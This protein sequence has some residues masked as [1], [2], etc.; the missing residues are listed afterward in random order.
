MLGQIRRHQKWLMIVIAGLTIVSFVYFLDPTT[1]RR[2][3]GGIFSRGGGNYGSINGRSI[4]AEEYARMKRE[5]SLRFLLNYGRWPD[6][7]ETTR[8]MF[9]PDRQTLEWIFLVEKANELN[10]QV[11]DDAITDWIANV[12]RDRTSGSFR[13]EAYQEFVQRQLRPRRLT[14]QDFVRFVRDQVAVQHL[15]VLA[16]LSGGLITPREAEALYREENEQLST[17]AALF[18]VSNYLAGVTATPEGL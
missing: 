18:S 3:G 15:S 6:E 17:E 12:F 2:S 5:A 10:V 16:G 1:G 11:N 13:V 14:E 8:Q 4:G 9:D 7:D